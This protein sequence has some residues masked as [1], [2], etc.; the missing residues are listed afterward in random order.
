MDVKVVTRRCR[1]GLQ[2]TLCK[3]VQLRSLDKG[4]CGGPTRGRTLVAVNVS[5]ELKHIANLQLGWLVGRQPLVVHGGA[6][7]G[8]LVSKIDFGNAAG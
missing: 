4:L 1:C 2:R 3:V 5:P 6:V 7:H 8:A